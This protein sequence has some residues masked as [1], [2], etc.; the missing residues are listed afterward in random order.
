MGRPP[1]SQSPAQG[2]P[3]AKDAAPWREAGLARRSFLRPYGAA[4]CRRF[5]TACAVGYY[6]SP[7]RG[8][9]SS[10][11]AKESMGS[12]TMPSSLRIWL[13]QRRLKPAIGRRKR[14]TCKNNPICADARVGRYMVAVFCATC[15]NR[16]CTFGPFWPVFCVSR[17]ILQV[18]RKRLPHLPHHLIWTAPFGR[19]FSILCARSA[20]VRESSPGGS[21]RAPA[22]P[23]APETAAPAP[24]RAC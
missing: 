18:P 24:R 8:W 10:R 14:G 3:G 15:K 23:S 4:R 17:L 1:E 5:P 19:T 20:G 7:L 12:N 11:L 21:F 2:P 22:R 13:D 9:K 16:F 6:L